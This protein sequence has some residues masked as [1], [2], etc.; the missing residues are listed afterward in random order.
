MKICNR[1]KSR[2]YEI[3]F[4]KSFKILLLLINH[5]E[6]EKIYNKSIK[7]LLGFLMK[8]HN[9]RDFFVISLK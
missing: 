2:C 6:E 8:N 9:G 1:N 3:E 4:F 5:E 7:L